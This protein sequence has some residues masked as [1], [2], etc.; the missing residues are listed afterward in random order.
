VR[1]Y[2]QLIELHILGCGSRHDMHRPE[3]KRAIASTGNRRNELADGV[4]LVGGGAIA[5]G[6][7]ADRSQ[8]VQKILRWRRQG[9]L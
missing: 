9:E 1:G 5:G 3:K 8:T 2:Q 4:R 7:L 6:G